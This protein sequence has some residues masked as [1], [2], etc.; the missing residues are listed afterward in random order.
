MK[1]APGSSETSVLTRATRR[2]NPE[3]TILHSHRRENLKSYTANVFLVRLLFSPWR[4]RRYVSLKCAVLTRNKRRHIAE[5]GFPLC[6]CLQTTE[7]VCVNM[8]T[9]EWNMTSSTVWPISLQVKLVL[10][11]PLISGQSATYE[12][13]VVH[14]NPVTITVGRMLTEARVPPFLVAISLAKAMKTRWMVWRHCL[15]CLCQIWIYWLPY[16]YVGARLS[17]CSDGLLLDVQGSVSERRIMFPLLHSF[18]AGSVAHAASCPMDTGAPFQRVK[19]LGRE[20]DRLSP[21][22]T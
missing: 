1:E 12:T 2:N 17:G 6:F 19:W 21:S 22:S 20:P 10:L 16:P 11:A 18:Q 5:D 8:N 15:M 9:G 13:F 4:L 14:T 7:I 3:D